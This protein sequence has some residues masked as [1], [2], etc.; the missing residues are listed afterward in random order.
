MDWKV[1]SELGLS[2]TRVALSMAALIVLAGAWVFD[3]VAVY[4]GNHADTVSSTLR[5]WCT[6]W[7]VLTFGAGIF[8]GHVL[9][10]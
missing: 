2:Y 7:P 9:W 5:D 3:V 10:P 8:V 6:R 1:M 4:N